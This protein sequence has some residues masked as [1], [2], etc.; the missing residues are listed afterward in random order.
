MALLRDTEIKTLIYALEPLTQ[1][2][3]L[4]LL[5]TSRSPVKGV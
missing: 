4:D 1:D 5:E 3:P 2:I